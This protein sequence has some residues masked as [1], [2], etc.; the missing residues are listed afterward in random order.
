MGSIAGMVAM[1]F[2]D[3]DRWLQRRTKKMVKDA[4]NFTKGVGEKITGVISGSN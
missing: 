1:Y 2:F 3:H 4:E